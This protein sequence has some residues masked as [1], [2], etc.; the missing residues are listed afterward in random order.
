M[1]ADIGTP[2]SA[3]R[4]FAL[5]LGV[6]V[7]IALGS[8]L[9]TRDDSG[10]AD[11]AVPV[12]HGSR[13]AAP[14]RG[15]LEPRAAL[16]RDDRARLAQLGAEL[17]ALQSTQARRAD[18]PPLGEDGLRSWTSRTPAAASAPAS[19]AAPAPAE[20]EIPFQWVGRW[21]QPADTGEPPPPPMAILSNATS[22]WVV[23]KGD[24]VA[25]DWKVE[26]IGADQIQ[27]RYLPTS[28]TRTLSLN[29]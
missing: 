28:S 20:P 26:G 9:A 12:S 13:D 7:A 21:D 18:F 4:R 14:A 5:W 6:S 16:K 23:K 25:V 8:A 11:I 29:P 24:V 3:G 19:L 27:L 2:R 17:A 1:D 15:P 10:D 22:T